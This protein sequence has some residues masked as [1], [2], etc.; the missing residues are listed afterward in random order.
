MKAMIYELFN[1]PPKIASVPD[2]TPNDDAVIVR[3]EATGI[4]RSDWYG[5]VGHAGDIALPHGRSAQRQRRSG[6]L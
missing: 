5:W 2:P 1:Q 6:P 4:C 3:V